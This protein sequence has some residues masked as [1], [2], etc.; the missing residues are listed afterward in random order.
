[1]G[2]FC[3]MTA[4]DVLITLYDL[5]IIK[6]ISIQPILKPMHGS[7]CTCQDCGWYHDE[8]VCEDNKIIRAIKKLEKDKI[9]CK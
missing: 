9:C 8:C 4:A 3:G 7:C 5:E 6:T 1:M 2:N